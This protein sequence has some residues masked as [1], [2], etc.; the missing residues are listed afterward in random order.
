MEIAE[1]KNKEQWEEKI[2]SQ[3]RAEFLQ[4]WDWAELQKILGRKIWRLDLDGEY[5]LAILMPLPFNQKYL[6]IPRTN[7]RLD[8]SKIKILADLALS[9]NCIFIRIEPVKQDLLEFGFR[10]AKAVQPVQTLLLDLTKS[11][12]DLSLDLHQKTRYNIR[13]AQKRGVRVRQSISPDEL[14]HFY[15]LIANTY[16]RKGI[17]VYNKDYYE[18][19]IKMITDAQLFLAEYQG[20]IL[21]AN[22]VLF[23]GDTVTYLHGG[24]S[25][26]DK[27]I[28]A[29][30]LLQWQTIT[31]A[32]KLGYKYYDFWGIDAFKWP[33]VTRFK[34]G[35]G[36]FE[37][38]YPG[39]YEL[40]IKGL[41]YVLYN[42]VK[43][44]K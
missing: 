12:E 10:Q 19:I 20:K 25:E 39:A 3:N 2:S 22:L 17:N 31:Q 26:E 4:S 43:R 23:Y 34:K 7:S 30:H 33:G 9:E 24:S 29:P 11:E 37:Y 14:D 5:V 35:F 6:Y 38:E 44:F 32:K 21:C 18:K 8:K 40:K 41:H 36:G 28:M 27:N 16:E 15:N 13:L 1:V 42:L